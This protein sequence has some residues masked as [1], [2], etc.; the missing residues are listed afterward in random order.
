MQK[1]SYL[2]SARN[3]MMDKINSDPSLSRDEIQDENGNNYQIAWVKVS[4][5]NSQT[6][7]GQL[8][9]EIDKDYVLKNILPNIGRENDI[10]SRI[11]IGIISEEEALVFPEET[12]PP[13]LGLASENL[14]HFFTKWKMVLFDT[15][16]RTVEN[17]V[18]R[19]KRLLGGALLGIFA[20]IL[21]GAALTL[22][23]AI[24]ETEV[25]RIKAEFVSNVSHE[26]KTPLSLIRLFGETLELEDIQDKKKRKKFTHIITRETQRLS[27]LVENVLDFSKIDAGRKEYNFKEEDIVEVVSHTLEAYKYYLRDQDFEF[28]TSLP[29]SSIIIKIDKD[30]VSQALL[31]LV[32]NAEK[33][34]KDKKYIRVTMG[35]KNQEVWISVE[36]KGPGIPEDSIKK[37]FNKF[38]RGGGELVRDV[39]G[40][41]LGLT[42]T[43][44]I[45][46]S[47]GGRIDVESRSGEG[48]CFILRL[49]LKKEKN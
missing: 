35:Q 44:H 21:G 12:P 42:I 37:I 39:Q 2:E 17:I 11:R 22:R 26:L 10:S 14:E 18:R 1:V 28:V 27:H 41:G 43:K 30:A 16:G 29:D 15:K 47:H 8:V 36:D 31:N 4:S 40:S 45:V 6:P 13:S 19:E 7:H 32:S 46:E 25:A 38:D 20:L 3:F 33:F 23:A 5:E 34:S 24:H 49:P 48:S 9:F